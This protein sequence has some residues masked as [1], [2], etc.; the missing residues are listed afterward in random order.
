[1]ASVNRRKRECPECAD[2]LVDGYCESCFYEEE[3]L[4]PD[5]TYREYDEDDDLD[6]DPWEDDFLGG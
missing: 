1:M 6:Y 2:E 3:D 4:T 5:Y